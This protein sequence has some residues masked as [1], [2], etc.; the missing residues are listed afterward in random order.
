MIARFRAV[1]WFECSQ[2]IRSWNGRI[3]LVDGEHWVH[4]QC[5]QLGL[6]LQRTLQ[7]LVGEIGDQTTEDKFPSPQ[8]VL[9]G[10]PP[11]HELRSSNAPT[12]APRE[13]VE[14]LDVQKQ[15]A[16]KLQAKTRFERRAREAL[17]MTIDSGK[18]SPS[19]IA[20][21]TRISGKI[22]FRDLAKIEGEAEGEI[23]GDEIEIAASA[24]VMAPITANRLKVG[25]QVVGEIVARERL[26]VLST[27]RLRGAITT[28]KLVVA[29]RA[30]I[31]GDCRM[32]R[33]ATSS[34]QSRSHET[35]E[36]RVPPF[37]Y[38]GRSNRTSQNGF[39]N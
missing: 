28:S 26:E 11:I 18:T 29:A 9:S 7:F 13:P 19:C 16:E 15:Q 38:S 23:T 27:A 1:Q 3:C 30:Q 12:T 5:W 14:Q 25:G 33:E 2:P 6:F 17:S 31:D 22:E 36:T 10:T 39:S 21:G 4:L 8:P 35:R 32:P 34:S 37:I 20:R 24:V